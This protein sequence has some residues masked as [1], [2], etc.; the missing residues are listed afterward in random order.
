MLSQTIDQMLPILDLIAQPA[1]CL[2]MDG[3]MVCNRQAKS[4][5]PFSAE[6][7]LPWLGESAEAY[8]CWDRTGTLLLSVLMGNRSVPVN[9]RGLQDG[10]LFLLSPADDTG[11]GSEFLSVAAQVLRQPLT[12][13]ASLSQQL[14][15][16]LEEMEDPLMQEQTAAM[17]RQLCRLSRITC[18]LADLEQLRNGTYLQHLEKLDLLP[19]LQNFFT[20]LED[21]CC[22]SGWTIQ[23][24]LPAKSTVILV[25]PTLLE[26][27]LLN[28]FSNAMKYGRKDMPI[29]FLAE[30]SEQSV[31]LRVKNTCTDSGHDFLTAA[32]RRT[33]QRG[34]LPDP[35]WGL[36]L[37]LPMTR[38]IARLMGGTVAVEVRDN[39]AAVTMSISR[40]RPL[41][42][43]QVKTPPFDYSGGMRHSLLELSDC[44]PNE[45]FD[46]VIL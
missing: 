14:T 28:L 15:E 37:G 29:Q 34:L 38:S 41:D 7:L 11:P 20:E 27:G 2:R 43:P 8:A 9:V 19:F 32:F 18:N 13:L 35:R 25:D 39:T 4:L 30:V 12:D 1:F 45:C 17:T 40:R 24:R 23:Y 6:D 21:I 42:P 22:Q 46:S 31:L 33:E 10:T 26:R 3:T 5:A 36:G 16:D 44:L